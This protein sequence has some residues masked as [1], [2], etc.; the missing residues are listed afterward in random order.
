MIHAK[1]N[2]ITVNVAE[3]TS[4]LEAAKK[5]QI[6][7]PT[8]C[9]HPDLPATAACGICIVKL[10][11]SN[12]MLRACCT[13]LE[14]N[15]EITT[16]DPEIVD[17]RRSVI[18]LILSR[19][20]NECLTCGRNQNCELQ[21]LAA[22]FGVRRESFPQYLPIF[23]PTRRTEPLFWSRANAYRADGASRFAKR[24]KTCGRYP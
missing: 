9:K 2:G 24:S 12:K 11:G 16:H 6:R 3:G 8:L 13:P 1:I 10:K 20:P 18:E 5:V 17:V 22:D 7:I 19:H 15:M 4:I 21:K 23:R 14:E